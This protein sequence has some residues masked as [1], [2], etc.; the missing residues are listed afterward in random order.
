LN[1]SRRLEERG[2]AP[3]H[4]VVDE[5]ARP[6]STEGDELEAARDP[7]LLEIDVVAFAQL[8]EILDRVVKSGDQI[9]LDTRSASRRRR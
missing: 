2:N 6:T 1:S 5:E 3:S 4:V 9:G 7:K 8:G